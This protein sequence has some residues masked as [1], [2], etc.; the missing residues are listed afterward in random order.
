MPAAAKCGGFA[1]V[2]RRVG[3]I[4]CCTAGAAAAR[5]HS[6]A[7]SSECGQFHVYS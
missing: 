7:H 6:T 4:D 1:A 2:G 5:G 3:D